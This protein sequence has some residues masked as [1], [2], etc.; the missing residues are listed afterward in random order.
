MGA[1]RKKIIW[2]MYMYLSNCLSWFVIEIFN[3]LNSSRQA[4]IILKTKAAFWRACHHGPRST[5]SFWG[6]GGGS[7]MS[8]YR[9][10][11]WCNGFAREHVK[12]ITPALGDPSVTTDRNTELNRQLLPLDDCLEYRITTIAVAIVE[13]ETWILAAPVAS[14]REQG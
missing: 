11:K 5:E 8:Q 1:N 9:A 12:G 14:W 6:G 4:N 10:Y 3:P 2:K 7:V 13:S